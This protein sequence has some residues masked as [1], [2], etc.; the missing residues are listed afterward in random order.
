MGSRFLIQPKITFLSPT[1]F[2]DEYFP[3]KHAFKKI[4]EAFEPNGSVVRDAYSF[5]CSSIEG[6]LEL[7]YECLENFLENMLFVGLVILVLFEAF[8]GPYLISFVLF[9]IT[10]L[11]WVM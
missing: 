3:V 10:S 6:K 2:Q 5:S 1:V 11:I 7:S 9:S 8:V 4:A